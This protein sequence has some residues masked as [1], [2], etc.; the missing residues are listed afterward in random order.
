[1]K[2]FQNLYPA[3]GNLPLLKVEPDWAYEGSVISEPAG[4]RPDSAHL[5][6]YQKELGDRALQGDP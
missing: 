4:A 6:T 1:M 2:P 5:Q 3:G